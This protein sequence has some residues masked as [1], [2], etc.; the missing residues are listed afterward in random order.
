MVYPQNDEELSDAIIKV[1]SRIPLWKYFFD[2]FT[3]KGEDLPT[4]TLW[5]DLRQIIGEDKLPPEDAKIKAS[6]V[7]KAYLDDI[8]YYRP[9]KKEIQGGSK[10]DPDIVDTSVT[11]TS[12]KLGEADLVK[13]LIQ[14]GAFEVAKI[15][16]DFIAGKT[17]TDAKET[18]KEE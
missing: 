18:E 12:P 9:V 13:G 16:I 15:F 4:D 11:T 10:V 8:K 3:A 7:R 5:M 1:I 2:N 17:K 6:L 14:H